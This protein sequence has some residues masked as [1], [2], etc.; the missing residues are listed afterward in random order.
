MAEVE[1]AYGSDTEED[2]KRCLEC[3]FD[4][5]RNC[6]EYKGKVE[7]AYSYFKG[8]RKSPRKI[9]QYTLEG[10]YICTWNKRIEIVEELG[11]RPEAISYCCR[12]RFK[13]AGGFIWKYHEE[14]KNV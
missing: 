5:C 9:D 14:E 2:I 6:L 8:K 13:Q 11:I 1:T 7:D 3:E 4:D 12:G 10:E